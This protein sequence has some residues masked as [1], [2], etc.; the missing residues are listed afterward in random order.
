MNA[1]FDNLISA[2]IL[3]DISIAA[4][5]FWFWLWSEAPRVGIRHRWPFVLATL[6]VGLCFAFPLFLYKRERALESPA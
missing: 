6:L 1:P 2:A 3:V 5:A 4:F